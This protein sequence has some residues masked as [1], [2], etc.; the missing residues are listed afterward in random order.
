MQL[1]SSYIYQN[2][3]GTLFRKASA[4]SFSSCKLRSLPVSLA[5]LWSVRHLMRWSANTTRMTSLSSLGIYIN[6][7]VTIHDQQLSLFI[8][9]LPSARLT[10][11]S[12]KLC[13]KC[14]IFRNFFFG[15]KVT[16]E[17]FLS[18]SQNFKVTRLQG[19]TQTKFWS[20]WQNFDLSRS[21]E[22]FWGSFTASLFSSRWSD[23]KCCNTECVTLKT[24]FQKTNVS[25]LYPF[26][27]KIQIFKL[28]VKVSYFYET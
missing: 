13:T 20:C 15:T 18:N 27:C 12:T 25:S 11:H 23:Q 28:R 19:C 6:H 14:N 9:N 16:S 22:R 5:R 4:R 2:D 24:S 21:F 10:L 8:D 1:L 17:E 7:Q 26:S 3:Y